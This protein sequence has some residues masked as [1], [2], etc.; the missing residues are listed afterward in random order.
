MKNIQADAKRDKHFV[1]VAAV[2]VLLLEENV[3]T[4]CAAT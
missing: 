4:P 3:P 1:V 2:R